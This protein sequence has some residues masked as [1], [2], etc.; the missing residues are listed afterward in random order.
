ML[1][2]SDGAVHTQVRLN[3]GRAA[4]LVQDSRDSVDR[5]PLSVIGCG[6]GEWPRAFTLGECAD[7]NPAWGPP[8]S[9]NH[10]S[11]ANVFTGWAVISGAEGIERIADAIHI[12]EK[13]AEYTAPCLRF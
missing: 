2:N 7:F 10:K 6:D 8:A 13:F 12:V 5:N 1:A 4:E 11:V 9:G 3:I